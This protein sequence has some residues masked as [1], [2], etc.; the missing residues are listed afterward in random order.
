MHPDNLGER[1]TAA[2]P[3][4]DLARITSKTESKSCARSTLPACSRILF[5]YL[6]ECLVAEQSRAQKCIGAALICS[7]DVPIAAGLFF[8]ETPGAPWQGHLR[9]E[10][11]PCARN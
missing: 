8:G 9:N 6:N 7:G 11:V 4:A 10:L 2:I 3:G 1:L 5:S